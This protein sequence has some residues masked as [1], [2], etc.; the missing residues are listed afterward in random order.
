MPNHERQIYLHQATWITHF[1]RQNNNGK[2]S[3]RCWTTEKL[4]NQKGQTFSTTN[5][6]RNA[7]SGSGM[8]TDSCEPPIPANNQCSSQRKQWEW[9]VL[10]P[11]FHSLLHMNRPANPPFLGWPVL[12][13]W[14]RNGITS[15]SH[16]VRD[17]DPPRIRIP[18]KE[19]KQC[20]CG[21][22]HW[23]HHFVAAEF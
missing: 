2:S 22:N 12:G 17:H 10:W 14:I 1:W 19:S 4:Y 7:N 11:I 3:A 16:G 5:V 6:L 18:D 20:A 13:H 15:K 9:H 23:R 21:D 8:S